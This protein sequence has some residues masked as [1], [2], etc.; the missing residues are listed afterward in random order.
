[1]A[2][3]NTHYR[4]GGIDYPAAEDADSGLPRLGES[5]ST[6]VHRSSSDAEADMLREIDAI[7][8][9]LRVGIPQLHREMDALLARV[10][11]PG[12]L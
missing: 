5:A 9:R 8:E 6:F 3:S 2:D 1:M 7:Q 10:R 11:T 4:S 12:T